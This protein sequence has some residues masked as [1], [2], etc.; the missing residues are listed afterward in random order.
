MDLGI[1]ND[2]DNEIPMDTWD[3]I[4]EGIFDLVYYLNQFSLHLFT[5]VH[6][7]LIS[8]VAI[9]RSIIW[10]FP[11]SEPYVNLNQKTMNLV[12][13]FI[14]TVIG[15]LVLS[16]LVFNA[17][18]IIPSTGDDITWKSIS[19]YAESFENDVLSEIEYSGANEIRR[20]RKYSLNKVFNSS[21]T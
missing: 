14:Y 9:Q 10:F 13:K 12:I 7:F 11:A 16:F 8:I 4:K 15:I 3:Y 18:S 20:S 6:C 1:M 21:A 2:D 17:F 19:P 5:R